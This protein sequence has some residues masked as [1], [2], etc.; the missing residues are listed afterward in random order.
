MT[1]NP[2]VVTPRPV[3]LLAVL[4]ACSP[5]LSLAVAVQPGASSRQLQQQRQRDKLSKDNVTLAFL[6][7]KPSDNATADVQLAER[8]C[9]LSAAASPRADLVLMPGRFLV[10]PHLC[11]PTQWQ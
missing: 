8:L 1:V 6:Q 4:C 10:R 7:L 9:R 11:T 5:W 3:R 2:R